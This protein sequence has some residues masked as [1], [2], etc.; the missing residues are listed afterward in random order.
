MMVWLDVLEVEVCCVHGSF[1]IGRGVK[2]GSVL[3]PALFLLVM[4]PLLQQLDSPGFGLSVNNYTLQGGFIHADD[5]RTLATSVDSL[6][7]QV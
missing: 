3:S 5:I 1:E 7:S 6:H 2:Q 4:N